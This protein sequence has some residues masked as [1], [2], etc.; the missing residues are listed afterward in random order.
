MRSFAKHVGFQ[1]GPTRKWLM[2]LLRALCMDREDF[3]IGNSA[4][5]MSQI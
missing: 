2:A 5:V 3:E 1:R 4:G